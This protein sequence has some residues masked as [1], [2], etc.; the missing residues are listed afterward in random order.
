MYQAGQVS[1]D[2]VACDPLRQR[3]LRSI[4]IPVAFPLAVLV[5]L[6]SGAVRATAQNQNVTPIATALPSPGK[7]TTVQAVAAHSPLKVEYHDGQLAI[8]AQDSSLAEIMKMVGQKTGAAVIIPTGSG[9]DHI[10]E[11]TGPGP[12]KT[13]LE[14]L[15]EGSSLNFVI[16]TSAQGSDPKR[17]LLSM[18][19]TPSALVNTSQPTQQTFLWTPPDT[20]QTAVPLSAEMDDTLV[21]PKEPM[22]PEAMSSF[23]KEKQKELRE[24]TQQQYPQ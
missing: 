17:I 16:V 9:L 12:I 23:M 11:H 4:S 15:L 7:T 6:H 21:A 14:H 24:K 5:C 10:V 8:D 22:T 20:S 3:F 18:Q 13:V 1:R 19:G 2:R